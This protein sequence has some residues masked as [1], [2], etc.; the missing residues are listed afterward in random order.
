MQTVY[1]RFIKD[2]LPQSSA[3]LASMAREVAAAYLPHFNA[4]CLFDDID[5]HST[6]AAG[7]PV[8]AH[9]SRLSVMATVGRGGVNE[10]SLAPKV[11][12]G[13]DWWLVRRPVCS[14]WYDQEISGPNNIGT[15][16]LMLP[17]GSLATNQSVAAGELVAE[18]KWMDGWTGSNLLFMLRAQLMRGLYFSNQT[19]VAQAFQVAF[20]A[21]HTFDQNTDGP[22][23]DHSFHQHGPQL[24]AGSYGSE[25]T[26]H[27]LEFAFLGQGTQWQ[28]PQDALDQLSGLLLE[29]Q[30]FM[31]IF[32]TPH[33]SD[34]ASR[35]R[36]IT[37]DWQVVGRS[38]SNAP[39]SS[40]PRG[41]ISPTY[42]SFVSQSNATG[43]QSEW[44]AFSARLSGTGPAAPLQGSRSYWDSDFVAHAPASGDWRFSLHMHSSRTIG[45]SCVNDQGKLS[46]RKSNGATALYYTG[47]E[48]D[49]TFPL[50]NFYRPPGVTGPVGGSFKLECGNAK[51][52]GGSGF[53]G[54][55]SLPSGR[56]FAV[57]DVDDKGE[58]TGHRSWFV[59][60][61]AVVAMGSKLKAEETGASF[62]TTLDTARL[63]NFVYA[64]NESTAQLRAE[65]SQSAVGGPLPQG[66]SAFPL[67]PAA[68]T[69]WLLHN[70]TGYIV[71]TDS[72]VAGPNPPAELKVWNQPKTG[73]WY[74]I[75]VGT[76]NV[77]EDLFDGR[78]AHTAEASSTG[79]S[80]A[81]VIVPAV[82]S[83]D[84]MPDLAKTTAGLTIVRS[85]E[86]AGADFAAQEAV[87]DGKA[88]V[89]GVAVW[90]ANAG[91]SGP[92][93][94]GF[95][96]I[97][98][99]AGWS[100]ASTVPGVLGMDVSAS[101]VTLAIAT[102]GTGGAVGSIYVDRALTCS[103]CHAVPSALSGALRG[104]TAGVTWTRVE[105]TTP[106]G[107]HDGDMMGAPTVIVA[108]QSS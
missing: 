105:F 16:M 7:W 100:I 11:V 87:L 59:F 5:Y 81:Y 39:G 70:N 44:Q 85:K 93:S 77:T 65:P 80:F 19:L 47:R 2:L 3:A 37:W 41:F 15:I 66:D 101:T 63:R 75:G 103:A 48:Y 23:D 86:A 96:D 102:P 32:D 95:S 98:A 73:N 33:P 54:G 50:W 62:E 57:M 43:R 91:S 61:N 46:R 30:Q 38:T 45:G 107:D 29:G 79:A 58:M 78:L 9:L 71:P 72:S 82:A 35:E 28:A 12:C 106:G 1:D 92:G 69:T 14:N 27:V 99:G 26:G 8:M 89:L 97:S 4:S 84:A 49:N 31:M 67:A 52:M 94:D 108:S 13:L 18:A 10:S 42:V 34:P 83:A 74:S 76:S 88:G 53:V 64:G 104:D 21:M 56:S 22:Q 36:S 90:T 6:R 51:S 24:L 20:S 40:D 55:V 68:G 25:F 17:N 60:D